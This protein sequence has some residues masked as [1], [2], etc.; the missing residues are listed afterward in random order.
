MSD[1]ARLKAQARGYEAKGD[2]PK[3]IDC[4]VQAIRLLESTGVEVDLSLYNRIG[5]LYLK[6]GQT[7]QAV[8]YWE[9]GIDA[10]MEAGFYNNAIALC[11]KLLR[12]VPSR[13]SV[14]LKLGQISARKGFLSDARKNFLE[15]ADRM[16]RAGKLDE[17]FRALQEFADLQPAP[18]IRL[19]LADQ[20][21]AHERVSQAVDQ[22]RFAWRD[23]TAEGRQADAGEVRA[24]IL[25]LAPGRDPLVD[26]P[27]ESP[28]APG[29]TELDVEGIIELPELE[30]SRTGEFMVPQPGEAVISEPEE[31]VSRKGPPAP[32]EEALEE[33]LIEP[34]E[35]EPMAPPQGFQSGEEA[36]G[37]VEAPEAETEEPVEGPE[38]ELLE[39]PEAFGPE[40]EKEAPGWTP[41]GTEEVELDLSEFLSG[42]SVGPP[43]SGTETAEPAET[44]LGG[45]EELPIIYP[46]ETV[47]PPAPSA[48]ET[49]EALREHL[50]EAPGNHDVRARLAE[51]LLEQGRRPEALRELRRALEGYESQGNLVEAD[52]IASELL[53]LSRNDVRVH[54]KRVELA[55]L[56]QERGQLVS[57]YLD[58]GDC[59]D[60]MGAS[61]KAQAVYE[62]VL[63]LDPGNTRAVDALRAL[64]AGTAA[65]EAEEPEAVARPAGGEV[66]A[67]E[68]EGRPAET[69]GYVDLGALLRAEEAPPSTRFELGVAEP[70][71]EEEFDFA[72]MLAQF[73]A[74]VA[75]GV[76]GEDYG[77][78][79][80]LG[81]AYKEMGLL[82]EAIAE[83]Q[84]AA[85][86]EEHRLRAQEM[87]G[88]CF[89]EKGEY[90]IAQ[91][92][93]LRALRFGGEEETLV[94]VLYDLG[95]VHEAL[96]EPARALEFFERV[97]SIDIDFQDV[98]SRIAALRRSAPGE[99]GSGTT[100]PG[101]PRGSGRR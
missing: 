95:R 49:V 98:A 21:L 39:V 4:Y 99:P 36:L 27:A 30:P 61:D 53:R 72:D 32:S 24:R 38:E 81:I 57:A 10:Y 79:Y 8:T 94:G 17:A 13:D 5:D 70:A 92:V 59:L 2:W 84:I 66:K 48:A 42:E 28:R 34:V 23:L 31:R 63:E 3:A 85:R 40:A 51:L 69:E 80:D 50:R 68:A 9:R 73:K 18:E 35:A 29:A 97:F 58:L 100:G 6:T 44:I 76:T 20:L 15:Y 65:V 46:E 91:K 101:G 41:G 82:D 86:G 62:R 77:S 14:Y 93:L 22:L 25:E 43:E 67:P 87:L 96:G 88:R 71:S 55:A 56:R 52:R 74:K 16:R 83:F 75:E 33:A 54:Q 64:G 90:R 47:T 1:L 37:Y 60:R 78:H 45:V 7:A 12:T 19:M 11:S 89:L 26:R